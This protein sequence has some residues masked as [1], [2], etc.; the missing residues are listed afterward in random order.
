MFKHE[1]WMTGLWQLASTPV[2]FF[3]IWVTM[4]GAVSPAWWLLSFGMYVM[5][6]L[7]GVLGMHYLFSHGVYKTWRP[8][9]IIL[10]LLGSL[11]MIGSPIQWCIAHEAHH[12]FAD[13]KLDPHNSY[14]WRDALLIGYR[15]SQ[16]RFDY[17]KGLV[18]DR[19]H[20]WLHKNYV[21]IVSIVPLML[22]VIDPTGMIVIFG[23]I[24]PTSLVLW[25]GGI[26]NVIS[27]GGA[28]PNR[29]PINLPWYWRL[30]VWFEADHKT[31]HDAPRAIPPGL[32]GFLISLI[33]IDKQLRVVPK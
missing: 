25:M 7:G 11:T 31:H 30:I 26:H 5:L 21:L 20:W 1:A 17:A 2:I 16:W 10:A 33:R 6:A 13:T 23:F 8:L 19:F 32:A 28:G 3:A 29:A 24:I 22:F 27:H 12:R 4:L 9:E 14:R 18:K 15:P